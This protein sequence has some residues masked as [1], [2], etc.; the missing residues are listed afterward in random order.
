MTTKHDILLRLIMKTY[1]R[2]ILHKISYIF[3]C[4]LRVTTFGNKCSTYYETKAEAS[5]LTDHAFHS[6]EEFLCY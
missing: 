1:K 6:A 5:F 2:G 4:I 3:K